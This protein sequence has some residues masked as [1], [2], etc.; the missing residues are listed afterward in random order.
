VAPQTDRDR[1]HDTQHYWIGVGAG[2]FDN[3]KHAWIGSSPRIVNQMSASLD[4]TPE[5]TR[6]LPR[7]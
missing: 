2:Q 1:E 4:V 3:L 5:I 6:H 7:H